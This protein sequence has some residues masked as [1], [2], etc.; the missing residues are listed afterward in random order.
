MRVTA[1]ITGEWGLAFLLNLLT[2][3]ASLLTVQ[4]FC[5]QSVQR[6]FPTVGKKASIAS[7]KLQL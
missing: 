1:G 6:R 4:R 5:L 3:G 2:V 7:Q